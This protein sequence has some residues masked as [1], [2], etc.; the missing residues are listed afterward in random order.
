[1]LFRIVFFLICFLLSANSFAEG[2]KVVRVGYYPNENF[3]EGSAGTA[4]HGYAYEY[5]QRIAQFTGWRY[6]YVFDS[7]SELYQKLLKGEIDLLAGLAYAKEREGLISYAKF[8]MG[9]DVYQL[10]KK[11]S[12]NDM[13]EN[14]ASL[15]GKTIGTL[16]GT[17][18]HVMQE[19]LDKNHIDAKIKVFSD[20]EDR[21][22]ALEM[23]SVDAV[24]VEKAGTRFVDGVESFLRVSNASYFLCV[25]IKRQDLLDELNRGLV[26]LS[27][28]DPIYL[29]KLYNK[30]MRSN[31][32]S[33]TIT[34]FERSWLE[35]HDTLKVAYLRHYLPYSDDREGVNNLANDSADRVDKNGDLP[36]GIVRD[37]FPEMLKLLGLDSL[38]L[39]YRSFESYD[40]MVKALSEGNVDVVFPVGGSLYHAEQNGFYESSPVIRSE[41][42]LIYSGEYNESVF[43]SF[44]INKNNKMMLYYI[45]ENFPNA[46]FKYYD[47]MEECLD[48]VLEGEVKSTVLSNLRSIYLLKNRRFSNLSTKLLNIQNDK[49]FGVAFGNEAL[50]RLM[51]RGLSLMGDDYTVNLS[52]KYSEKLY[53]ENLLETLSAHLDFVIVFFT[54]LIF[55]IVVFFVSVFKRIKKQAIK[56]QK[57]N[58]RL[59]MQLDVIN[60]VS[61]CYHSV[62]LVD[63][64]HNS[65]SIIHTF[66]SVAKA[67]R[68]IQN[69]AQKALDIMV[70]SMILDKYKD[71]VKKFN[72]IS[73]WKSALAN[74]NSI[75]VEYEGNVR[76]W[77]RATILVARRD[78][79]GDITHV[80]Y[81]S[82][83]IKK[84]KRT[85]ASLQQALALAE[86]ANKAKTLFL[87]N[88]SHDIRTP[89]NAIIGFTALAQTHIDN[90]ERLKDYLGKI[91]ISSEHLLS[92]INDVLEMRRIESGMV[93]LEEKE[94]H[95]PDLLHDIQTIVYANAL[96][97][98][99]NLQ[100]SAVDVV[101]EDVVADK[102]RLNQV[103]LNLLSN[104]IKFT[105]EGGNI[106]LQI[107]EKPCSR[108]DFARY[109]F[110]VKDNGIG[111][112]KDFQAHI[113]EAFTREESSTVSGIQGTGLGMSITKNI[114]NMMGGT[115][116]IESEEGVGSE[117]IVTLELKKC[118]TVVKKEVTPDLL[119]ERALVVGYDSGTS[120]NV[121]KMLSEIGMEPEWAMSSK[122]AL[123][124]IQEAAENGKSFKAFVIDWSMLDT[125]NVDSI[126]DIRKEVGNELPIVVLASCE[127]NDIEDDV[128]DAGA[129][130]LCIKPL[131]KSELKKALVGSVAKIEK[132]ETR[133][134][135]DGAKILLAED[136]LLNQEIASTILTEAGFLVDVVNNGLAAVQ[137]LDESIPE[138]YQVVL[139]DIQMPIMD[140]YEATRNIRKL[141]DVT[142]ASIPIVAMTANA[143]EE[144]KKRAFDSGMDGHLSKPVD[145]KKL[146]N[147]LSVVLKKKN[148]VNAERQ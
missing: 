130:A 31:A 59:N 42:D 11:N 62:F 97:K 24:I 79:D 29:A 101:N 141:A 13:S 43:E 104:A 8:P 76:G 137:K 33:K 106:S 143:F 92:L 121:I 111:M 51:N 85:E 140:G 44:A 69:D 110:R 131:F 94:T 67:V 95:L 90:K 136:N 70:D 120:Q 147:V 2:Q 65:F 93:K 14:P 52:Y 64:V 126:R 48:A 4:L 50:L 39:K 99:Q 142:K 58:E 40:Q 135:F 77:C 145:V 78:A 129:T 17:M 16:F 122:E 12:R 53:D 73:N 56:V 103:L 49:F 117:F 19:F 54:M 15:Q 23:D 100:V 108:P 98:L 148:S 1:M 80:L 10:L 63:V 66:D 84:Q 22:L 72:D 45:Q 3:Q 123:L 25:N 88:M 139:M 34:P 124:R 81:V 28:A 30:Y 7:Y 112:S 46:K 71:S 109:E 6:E 134:H 74:Q 89:M 96:Q 83:E 91:T 113:F 82:Q 118:G 86:K 57:Q 132:T 107:I 87:N 114:V 105:G 9:Y 20:M 146:M 102:L 32:G 35:K 133:Q 68:N 26:Q 127:K 38:V 47:S 128:M 115:I 41:L 61:E 119:N 116:D 18:E 5:Y 60:S 27:S 138:T 125:T 36:T 144:D 55:L 75:D 21:D 37:V